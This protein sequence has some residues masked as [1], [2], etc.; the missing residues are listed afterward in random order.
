L[1]QY[2]SSSFMKESIR[3]INTAPEQPASRLRRH[4]QRIV[5]YPDRHGVAH[6]LNY[7]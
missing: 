1:G 2:L 4:L 5:E 3:P 6:G 7:I